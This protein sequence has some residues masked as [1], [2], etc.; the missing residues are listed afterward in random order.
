M[1][2]NELIAE[3]SAFYAVVGTPFQTQSSDEHVP[4]SIKTYSVLIYEQGNSEKSKKPVICSRYIDFVVCNEGEA[5]E[6]AYYVKEEIKNCV[7]CDITGDDSLI[8][9]SK[10]FSS[11]E[12]QKRIRSAIFLA[13]QNIFNES[14]PSSLLTENGVISTN[15]VTV[16]DSSKFTIGQTIKIIDD[17]STQTTTVSNIATNTITLVDNLSADFLTTENARVTCL[18]NNDRR[19]WASNA[20]L[21]IEQYTL[22]MSSFVTTNSTVQAN[23]NAVTD[24]VLQ[25][26]VDSNITKLASASRIA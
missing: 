18:D 15:T 23:G 26:I 21:N 20:L 13:T 1:T 6:T 4:S 2:K 24:I 7:N 3:M 5:G 14:I 10:I 16:V 9:I 12:I 19:S 17:S 11:C 22:A 25:G 8:S